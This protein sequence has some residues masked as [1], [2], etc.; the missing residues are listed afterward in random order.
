MKTKFSI[1]FLLLCA[2]VRIAAQSSSP[3]LKG[4]KVHVIEIATEVDLGMVSYVERAVK[5]AE[6]EHAAIL[7]HVNTFGG[8]VDAATKIRDAILNAKVPMTIA[9]VGSVDGDAMTGKMD[10]GAFGAWPFTGTRT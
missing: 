2:A 3:S 8:R 7:L 4:E 10:T 9:F 5:E 6:D 1:G